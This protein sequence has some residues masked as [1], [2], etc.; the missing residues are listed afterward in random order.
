MKKPMDRIA[1]SARQW[2]LSPI[3]EDM[4]CA[5]GIDVDPRKLLEMIESDP[6]GVMERINLEHRADAAVG[7]NGKYEER[8][9]YS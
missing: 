1:L 7:K 2:F 8:K 6:H 9:K 4:L 3:A 5:F